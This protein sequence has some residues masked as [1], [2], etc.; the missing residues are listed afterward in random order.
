MK[1]VPGGLCDCNMQRTMEENH[2]FISSL[3]KSFR[4]QEISFTMYANIKGPRYLELTIGTFRSEY[5]I[6]IEIEYD[7]RISIQLCFQSPQSSV[8][9]QLNRRLSVGD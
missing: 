6:E 8:A 7:Y 4:K 5:E 3:I 2:S 1:H 9:E